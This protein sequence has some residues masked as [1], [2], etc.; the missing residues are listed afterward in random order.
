MTLEARS[1]FKSF[2]QFVI[3]QNSP[4]RLCLDHIFLR[5]L[6]GEKLAGKRLG[7]PLATVRER[8]AAARTVQ[9]RPFNGTRLLTDADMGSAEVAMMLNDQFQLQLPADDLLALPARTDH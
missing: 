5:P 2:V 9:A 6:W 1:R 8:V 3:I 4:S 7:E